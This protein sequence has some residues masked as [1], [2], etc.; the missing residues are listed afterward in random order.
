MA[1]F[2]TES[3]ISSLAM[4]AA[5]QAGLKK[6]GA[7][8]SQRSDCDQRRGSAKGRAVPTVD[9]KKKE[10]SRSTGLRV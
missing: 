10:G 2:F 6:S 4:A 3:W 1:Y 9:S 5:Q 7:L 8:P